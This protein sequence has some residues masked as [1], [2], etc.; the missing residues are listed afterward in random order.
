MMLCNVLD[1]T[2]PIFIDEG[3]HI[4]IVIKGRRVKQA[5]GY[6]KSYQPKNI[7]GASACSKWKIM[8]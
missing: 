7:S 3:Y 2:K 4:S 1:N 5:C 8:L 6:Q